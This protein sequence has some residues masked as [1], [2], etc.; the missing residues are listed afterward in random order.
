MNMKA[1]FYAMYLYLSY[2]CRASDPD[3]YSAFK[4]ALKRFKVPL[5][6]EKVVYYASRF[7]SSASICT[8][9]FAYDVH[10][11]ITK[12]FLVKDLYVNL[13]RLFFL[14]IS[15]YVISNCNCYRDFSDISLLCEGFGLDPEYGTVEDLGDGNFDELLD[16][17]QR[18]GRKLRIE[19][20]RGDFV[21]ALD[22][23]TEEI[24]ANNAKRK[25]RGIRVREFQITRT[26]L[27]DSDKLD[28]IKKMKKSYRKY[29]E[30]ELFVKGD[31][32]S[33]RSRKQPNPS[34]R[35]QV[36]TSLFDLDIIDDMEGQNAADQD[37]NGE[38]QRSN[39]N[40]ESDTRDSASTDS[41]EHEVSRLPTKQRKKRRIHTTLV[42]SPQNG[43]TQ[44]DSPSPKK[45]KLTSPV[46][47]I[48][49]FSPPSASSAST[50]SSA[51]EFVN[52][53][54]ASAAKS[55]MDVIDLTNDDDDDDDDDG[56]TPAPASTIRRA[57]TGTL[58]NF[59]TGRQVTPYARL[60]ATRPTPQSSVKKTQRPPQSALIRLPLTNTYTFE[61]PA[62]SEASLK[63]EFDSETS[64]AFII[65]P[66]EDKRNK[67]PLVTIPISML[68]KLK[69]HQV[70]TFHPFAAQYFP[71]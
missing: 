56:N 14:S 8:L 15:H 52:S 67:D 51:V 17:V 2:I 71:I 46:A 13:L 68:G 62:D 63:K 64:S 29:R 34:R 61:M 37:A 59:L 66:T 40:D 45:S 35:Q 18:E 69:E 28:V 3:E 41:G 33:R 47:D 23:E 60:S 49:I 5:H 36:T 54:P 44:A 21:D 38:Q 42:N 39:S 57:S 24:A 31:K 20:D 58:D 43:K 32:S 22:R 16:R 27:D 70:R 12:T 1:K 25:Q 19:T 50:S 10:P 65:N 7:V 48:T 9:P 6:I 11:A 55:N 53:V 26:V 4:K 30:G